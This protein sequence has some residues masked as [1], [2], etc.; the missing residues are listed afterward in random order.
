MRYKIYLVEIRDKVGAKF[1]PMYQP[2]YSL[3]EAQKKAML[4]AHF[5]G[6]ERVRVRAYERIEE[7]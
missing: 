5:F 2:C 6:L 3:A 1:I 4:K 7:L